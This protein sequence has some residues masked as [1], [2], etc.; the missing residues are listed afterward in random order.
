MKWGSVAGLFALMIGAAGAPGAEPVEHVTANGRMVVAL[1]GTGALTRFYWPGTGSGQ[2]LDTPGARWYLVAPEGPIPLDEDA[3]LIDQGYSAPDSLAVFTRYTERAG[4]RRAEQ[5]VT[6]LPG[7][8]LLVV[9]LRLYGFV[10]DTRVCWVQAFLPFERQAP[11]FPEFQAD[12]CAVNGFASG[13][14]PA[15]G[16]LEQFRPAGAGQDDGTKL[17]AWLEG[18]A[19]PEFAR[20]VCIGTVSPQKISGAFAGRDWSSWAGWKAAPPSPGVQRAGGRST[21]IL[22]L[23][24]ENVVGGLE[25]V[26]V[27]G[28]SDSRESLKD[29]LLSSIAKGVGAGTGE[30]SLPGV[31]W[32]SQGAVSP[33]TDPAVE[34]A[35]LNLLLCMD[36]ESGAVLNAPAGTPLPPRC[37]VLDSAWSSAAMDVLG[38]SELAGRAL[39]HHVKSIRIDSGL[40][41]P[42]GSLPRFT[43]PNGVAASM[44]DHANPECAAWLLAACCRHALTLPEEGRTAYLE[45]IW[46]ALE[47]AVDYLAR[48][49]RVGEA[50]SG[51]QPPLSIAL[52][53]LRTHYL[54]L[55]S[56]R[57]IAAL[58]GK[59]EP[60]LWSDRRGEIYSRIR[61]RKLNQTDNDEAYL[62]WIDWWIGML[63]G[64]EAGPASGSVP[65]WEVL[66]RP[67]APKLD[68]AA[69]LRQDYP[70]ELGPSAPFA[71]RDAL[72]CLIGATRPR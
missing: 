46:P 71:R 14:D 10:P 60:T 7:Q 22:E 20:G 27:I 4:L 12:I 55:E 23:Q 45:P 69:I 38:Y 52:D 30:A 11:G 57:Q 8:D 54:G 51:A 19:A 43:Y 29:L 5:T 53:T 58:L 32:L 65:G 25:A 26:V 17:G 21:G 48:E 6:A 50:L 66:T 2:H 3:W 72:R 39:G 36:A 62:P 18:E 15:T 61:F 42:A 59:S 56:G 33:S 67:G 31:P 24:P 40:D 37:D 64:G 47:I 49:P 70:V 68:A 13:F 1:D 9:R 44:T 34:R 63:P 41:T 16:M 28:A 35:R